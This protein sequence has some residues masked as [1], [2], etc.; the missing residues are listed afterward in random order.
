MESEIFDLD[1]LEVDHEAPVD[2]K[3]VNEVQQSYLNKVEVFLPRWMAWL[4]KN[5]DL[6]TRFE[7]WE[8]VA[9]R[10]LVAAGYGLQKAIQDNAE[11]ALNN[12]H[13]L[14]CVKAWIEGGEHKHEIEEVEQL[15]M[16]RNDVIQHLMPRLNRI[17]EV[18]NHPY[19]SGTVNFSQSVDE[20]LTKAKSSRWGRSIVKDP[21]FGVPF[22]NTVSPVYNLSWLPEDDVYAEYVKPLVDAKE[23]SL[24]NFQRRRM[25]D[26]LH[27]I[28]LLSPLRQF[29]LV[30]SQVNGVL[31]DRR[32]IYV[33]DE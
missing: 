6:L 12:A 27:E 5:L 4:D 30:H 17:C 20:W 24:S 15:H 8:P 22:E 14:W 2:V 29:S 31:S 3:S 11:A 28:A 10:N 13:D 9:E 7:E 25:F 21:D 18:E 16:V 26:L 32:A 1:Y 19:L 33:K 23:E